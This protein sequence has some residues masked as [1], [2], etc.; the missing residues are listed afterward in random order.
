MKTKHTNGEWRIAVRDEREN[1]LPAAALEIFSEKSDGWIAKVQNNGVI[2]NEEGQ[3]NAKI[4]AA[5]PD[6]L[7]A[8]QFFVKDFEVD[9]MVDGKIVDSPSQLLL[10]NYKSALAAIKKA[11]E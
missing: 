4:I 7:L 9:F 6:L 10:V 8:L 3:A 11:T 1:S 2:K 5:A